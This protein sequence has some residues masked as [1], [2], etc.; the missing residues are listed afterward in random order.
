L[1][2]VSLVLLICCANVAG[3]LLARSE[4]RRREIALRRA[5]GATRF[6]LLRQLLTEGALLTA[7]GCALGLL[8]ADWLIGLQPSLIPAETMPV[9]LDLRL[10]ARVVAFT[11]VSALATALFVGLLPAFQG[12]RKSLAS[13]LQSYEPH[14][15][16]R[17]S[18][19]KMRNVFVVAEIGLSVTLL[20]CAGL[21]ARS[22]AFSRAIDLGVDQKKKLLVLEVVPGMAENN[23]GRAASFFE[24]AKARLEGIRGVR[25]VSK[26]R[27]YP[28]S[29]S[30]GGAQVKVSIPG[31][32]LPGQ[33]TAVFVKYN[34]VDTDYFRSVGTHILKGRDFSTADE[35][36]G[37]RV[38]VV[39][40]HMA[41]QFW[42]DR[43]PIGAHFLADGNDYQ[44]IGVA[45]DVRIN[46][47]HETFEPYLYLPFW[48][49]ATGEG[50]L[51]VETD[52]NPLAMAGT[53][54]DVIRSV[55][56]DV[57]ILKVSTSQEILSSAMWY[58]RI[59]AMVFGDLSLLGAALAAIGLYGVLSFVI[60]RRRRELGVR[61]ALGAGRRDI[62]RLVLGH[63]L[64]LALWGTTLGL[65]I[66]F[67]GSRVLATSL[68]GVRPRDA[69]TFVGASVLAIAISLAASYLPARRAMRV[70]PMEVLRFE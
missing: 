18:G 37:S 36:A 57:P 27:R 16:S 66:A 50:T 22:F 67:A 17:G 38:A 28:L 3:L 41:R 43:D 56:R 25:R 29:P 70:D 2:I 45:Q 20:V 44:I 61:I 63:G 55:N 30:G 49:G 51:I 47:V 21:F 68:Y 34:S 1:S 42:K 59:A 62:L 13:T 26:A 53:V 52:R 40:L 35:S 60:N 7:G 33:Q 6:R 4:T 14:Y 58:E 65:V 8:L 11:I 24:T 48:R 69:V 64:K 32:E 5:M 19:L 15:R 12:S 10:D 39:S 46:D 31:V 54:R 23:A 9:G